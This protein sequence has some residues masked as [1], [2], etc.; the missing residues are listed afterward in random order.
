MISPKRIKY[1]KPH[2][3]RIGGTCV[4]ENSVLFGDF[5]LQAKQFAWVTSRQIES[6]RRVL[7]RY[8][9]RGGKLWIRVFPD[10]SVTRRAAET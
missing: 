1:R 2:R 6:R 8:T 9:R 5:G 3:G 7:T 4:Y 10:K